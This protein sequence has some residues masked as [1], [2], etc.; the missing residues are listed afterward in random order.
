MNKITLLGMEYQREELTK[1]LMDL[2]IV[3]I[4]EVNMD[5]Y[6]DVAEN[7]EVSDSLSRIASELIHISSSLDIINK[8][9]P[10]KKPVV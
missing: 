3:D 2:G 8:Y 1:T 5:D 9:S 6:E 10:A 4:S 7:P